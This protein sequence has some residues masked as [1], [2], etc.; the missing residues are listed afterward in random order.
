MWTVFQVRTLKE[1]SSTN[2]EVMVGGCGMFQWR[3]ILHVSE[4]LFCMDFVT[5]AEDDLEQSQFLSPTPRRQY[6]FLSAIFSSCP[7]NG[8]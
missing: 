6:K 2:Q 5:V 7:Q 3:D 1:Q 4:D 8:N